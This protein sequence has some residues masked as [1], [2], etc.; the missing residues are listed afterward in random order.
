MIIFCEIS[1]QTSLVFWSYFLS[2]TSFIRCFFAP[3][4]KYFS[5][6]ILSPKLMY[7]IFNRPN[8]ISLNDLRDT[9]INLN[10]IHSCSYLITS[11]K[12][13]R[14]TLFSLLL[15]SS[16]CSSSRICCIKYSSPPSNA[17]VSRAK[18]KF[19]ILKIINALCKI[20][21]GKKILRC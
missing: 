10:F 7:E 12:A 14:N 15:Y 6:R 16:L 11:V 13:Q 19:V 18:L 3:L 4:F 8:A 5:C 17:A 9:K 1:V 2:I 21:K 20:K